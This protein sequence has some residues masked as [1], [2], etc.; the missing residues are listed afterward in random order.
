MRQRR[1]ATTATARPAPVPTIAEHAAL[2]H[3][4]AKQPRR[5]RADRAPHA[6]LVP[7]TTRE[8]RHQTRDVHDRDQQK[9]QRRREQ[10]RQ[11]LANVARDLLGERHHRRRPLAAAAVLARHR[12]AIA[13]RP[14]RAR[15]TV[16]PARRRAIT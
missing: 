11:R 7:A 1:V 16:A 10:H 3:L 9:Q 8:R 6:E 5:R 4:L 13:A 14:A 2:R 12:V 15:S